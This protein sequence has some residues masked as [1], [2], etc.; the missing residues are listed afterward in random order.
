MP[1]IKRERFRLNSGTQ[2]RS[3]RV[4]IL[5]GQ[6][7]PVFI[8]I[9]GL[10]LPQDPTSTLVHFYPRFRLQTQGLTLPPRGEM[11]NWL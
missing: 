7:Q 3:K 4:F 5:I 9:P 6:L 2:R 8:L 11:K 1:Q 10:V